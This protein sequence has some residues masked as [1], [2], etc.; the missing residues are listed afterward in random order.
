VPLT[1]KV[2][3]S[4]SL[5]ID[6]NT[7]V[8]EAGRLFYEQTTGTGIAPVL[9]YSDGSTSG[10]LP[11]SGSS[12]TF[13]GSTPPLNPHDGLLWWDINDGRLYIYY[14]SSWIDASPEA[15]STNTGITLRMLSVATSAT[16]TTGGA[17]SYDNTIGVFTYTP[18]DATQLVNGGPS[19]TVDSYGNLTVPGNVSSAGFIT[20]G[21]IVIPNNGVAGG[22]Q[23]QNGQGNIYFETDNSLNFIITGTWQHVF[24]ADGTITFGGGY[25]FPNTQGT[26]GQILVYDPAGNGDYKLS[27]QN[28]ITAVSSLTNDIG[29]LTSATVNQYVNSFTVTNVSYFTNDVG[30]LTNSSVSPIIANSLT[31]YA[32]QTY[33]TTRG[34]ITADIFTTTNISTFINDAHYIQ[35]E[36]GVNSVVGTAN[37]VIVTDLGGRNIQLSTPQNLNTTATVQ[38]GDLTVNNISILGTNTN[39]TSIEI[40]GYRLYLA[41]S[42]TNLSQINGGGVQLGTTA[43]GVHSIFWNSGGYWDTDVDGIKTLTLEAT[44]STLGTLE[45]LNQARFGYV[46]QD[47]TLANAYIQVDSNA[48]N[49]SQIAIVNHNTGTNASADI[50]ATND[51]GNDTTGFID[52]GINSSVFS[53]SSWIINGANDGYLYVA[54]GNLAIG[55]DQVSGEIKTFLGSTDNP[56]IISVATATTIT[57]SV[58][59]MPSQDAAY[60][61]GKPGLR[62]KGIY[63]GTGSLWIQDVSLGT[64]AELTVDAGVLYVNGAY[65]LQVG[66]LKFFQNTIEST[67]GGTDIQ[68]GLTTST[69]NLVLNRNTVIATGKSLVFGT[70]GLQT[71]AWNS[72]ATVLYNQITGVP[73]FATTATVTALIANS[74]TNYATQTYVTTRGYITSS[75][76]SVTTGSAVSGGALA[77]STTTGVFTFNPATAYTLTTATNSALGGVKIGANITAAGDGTISVAAPYTLTTGTASALGGVKI[78]SGINAAGDGTISVTPFNT[79]TLVTT[80][81]TAN[82]VAGGYVSSITAGTGTQVSTST[83]AVTVWTLPAQAITSTGTTTT[84]NYTL[85]LSGPTF[86]HWQPTANGDQTVTLTGFAPGRKVQVFITPHRAADIFTFTGVTT[87]Q[88]S[89]NLN[90]FV[91]G[92]GGVAQKSMMIE[93]FCTTNAIGGVWIFGYGSQ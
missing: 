9:K 76:L 91:L 51:T 13:S 75:S 22:I 65:Q 24:N 93:I 16:S 17:L 32:T 70:G 21:T 84:T 64:D 44:T 40:Q 34:Y 18:A 50:V 25:I 61:L 90:T 56:T 35:N 36:T 82:T 68:I 33:V 72:T 71:V 14:D 92:G 81:V 5:S 29:Y 8:G 3:S 89:N 28:Q 77:Y 60:Q 74:L 67:T 88:C 19:V 15:N 80:A 7:F 78:G 48:N 30:Y 54:G 6:S 62:W 46:N 11:L 59:L 43:T 41:S 38:F 45:V 66:Q 63:V 26:Q 4:R 12:L 83:G 86:V 73:G 37:Q 52:M 47:L 79:S 49:F 69:A 23:S 27:W 85:D 57:Y 2:Y 55:T 42:A 10:G 87:S 39:L 31:N 58:D 20:S 53:T 1:H